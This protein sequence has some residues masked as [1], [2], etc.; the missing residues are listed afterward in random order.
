MQPVERTRARSL[1]AKFGQPPR[2]AAICERD[3]GHTNLLTPLQSAPRFPGQRRPQT[4][5]RIAKGLLDPLQAAPAAPKLRTGSTQVETHRSPTQLAQLTGATASPRIRR[6]GC[7]KVG[8]RPFPQAVPE[9]GVGKL[10]RPVPALV[11]DEQPCQRC[12]VPK[13][14]RPPPAFPWQGP[15][16][17]GR[18]IEGCQFPEPQYQKGKWP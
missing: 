2:R 7:Y 13:A 4:R 3:P 10:H 15:R 18:T 8:W 12:V 5:R 9:S 11:S 1:P 16:G 14:T 17:K 6:T